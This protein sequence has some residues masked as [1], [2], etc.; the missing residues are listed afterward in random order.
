MGYLLGIDGG[1]TRTTAWLSD[2]RGRVLARA[3]A[4]PANPL[5]VGFE[6]CES[7]LEAA[8][9][10]ALHVAKITRTTAALRSAPKL[11]DAVVV[12]LA[13]VDRPPVHAR[14]LV[15]LKKAIPAHHH[16]LT[17]DAAIALEAAI[18]DKPGIM[19]ISGTGS[20]AY[21]RDLKGQ[22]LRSGGWGTLFDDAG[23]GYEI[24]RCAIAAALRDFDGRGSRTVLGKK[25]C[26]ALK[27]QD[28]TR[29]ILKPLSPQEIAALFPLVLDAAEDGD[30]VAR[31]MLDRA[32]GDLA[33]LAVALAARL[34]W[35]RRKFT[36]V[37]AGGV[38]NA[39]ARVRNKF[40]RAL[41][42]ECPRT[43]LVHLRR[44]TVEGA[45]AMART[46]AGR[47]LR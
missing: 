32:G 12:G 3:E 29:I 47:N 28:I 40:A 9:Q 34:G 16:L 27:L 5:K 39:S 11:L 33:E 30:M 21:A 8:A 46:I 22:A 44:P 36:V 4:G 26:R 1:G 38:F 19:V 13:G 10:G 24:G 15:W 41:R 23:S 42:A 6:A 7:A 35:K 45:L 17:S 2:E 31:E 20:I 37:A 18:G 25:I 43:K 14:L